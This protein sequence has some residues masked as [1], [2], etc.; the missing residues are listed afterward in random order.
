MLQENNATQRFYP[1]LLV[2]ALFFTSVV[3]YLDRNIISLFVGPIRQEIGL[4]DVQVSLLQGIAFALLYSV[5]GLPFGRLVD[6]HTRKT[7]IASGVLLWSAMTICCGLSTTFWQLFFSRMGVGIGEACLGP[8]A[9]S[10]IADCFAP[11]QRGRAIASY[12]MSNYVGVGISLL[13]G[14]TIISMLT[15]LADIGFT[16]LSSMPTWRLAFVIAGLP[17]TLMA[18]VVLALKEPQR[19]EVMQFDDGQRRK[20][21]LWSY[22][23]GRKS[24]FVSIYTVYTLTAMIGYIVVAWAPSFYIRHHHMRPADVGLLMG[25]MTILS[26]VTGCICGGYLSDALAAKSVRGGRFRLPLLWWPI[27]VATI[28]G[29]VFASS[30]TWS[31]L[32]LGLLTFGSALSFSGAATVIQDVVP[33]QLRGQAAALN[34]IW[35]GIIGLSLGPTSV[36]MVTQYVLKDSS[37]LGD[38][39]AI[40]VVP[41]SVVGFLACYLGQKNYQEARN[42]L[43]ATLRTGINARVAPETTQDS[44]SSDASRQTTV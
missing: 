22:L 16:G 40:V 3:S 29:M 44:E 31:L 12:N 15:R 39:L 32:F 36:A 42:D 20:L 7:L 2:V 34:Y 38:A 6:H 9:F 27:A 24:A 41:L 1:W 35:T 18:F 8:A 21:G 4:S 33:N 30:P 26:G 23:S 11:A 17:G 19:R 10:M 43:I 37:L 13:F 14:G 5:M 28:I 25:G